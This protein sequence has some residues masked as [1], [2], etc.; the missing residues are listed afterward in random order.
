[1]RVGDLVKDVYPFKQKPG[2]RYGVII[3][4]VDL[5]NRSFGLNREFKVL[6]SCGAIG[7]KVGNYD[8][9]VVSESCTKS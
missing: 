8:L 3:G 4:E 5:I 7:N 9:E 2:D 6:W 1:M